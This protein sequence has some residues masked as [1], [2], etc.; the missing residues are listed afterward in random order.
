[1]TGSG[2]IQLAVRGR[3]VDIAAPKQP[4][5]VQSPGL[6]VIEDGLLLAGEG[7][8]QWFGHYSDGQKR[9]PEGCRVAEHV[10]SIIVPGFIDCHIHFP[11][12]EI[13]GSYGEQL[14]E[15]LEKYAF[16]AEIQYNDPKYAA[17][18]AGLFLDQLLQNGTTTAMV[19]CTVHPQSAEALFAAAEQRNMRIIGGKV[20]MDRNCPQELRDT[21]E[22]GYTDSKALIQR[23]HGKNR[24]RYALTPRFA[25]TSTPE[26]L[27]RAGALL[28]EYPDL[29][30]QTHLAEN[31]DEIHWVR[32]L[33]PEQKNYLQVYDHFGLTGKQCIFAHCLHLEEEEW[34]MLRETGSGI[35][36]CPTSN[37]FLGSGLF[38]RAAA[39]NRGIK[40]GLA[41]DVGGGTWMGML[42]TMG[43]AY[44]VSQLQGQECTPADLLYL[45]TL[46]A[47]ETLGLA[48][49]LGGF[50]RGREADFIV[51][52]PCATEL[53][54]LRTGK[55]KT[56]EEILF[57]LMILGDDRA[58]SH[59]YVNGMPA[60]EQ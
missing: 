44:K 2:E 36:F 46:G 37:L 10:Q 4:G 21:P 12:M 35:A 33:F 9:I 27:Q 23:W 55:A 40:V 51:L 59:T 32:E 15:W 25:P 42:Q 56:V 7:C 41:T 53:L 58:I 31:R 22:S 14:L 17:A 24:L 30:M 28:A 13:I 19:F 26:Q 57:S 6:R 38:D 16:P 60:Y 43:E 49:R 54:A 8:I 50:T 47:A 20:L 48:H 34:T 18:M 52:D 11:Q 39:R 1:L 3:F 45:A 29:Y 5:A